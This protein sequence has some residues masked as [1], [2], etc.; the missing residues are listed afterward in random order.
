MS[1]FRKG[2]EMNRNKTEEAVLFSKVSKLLKDEVDAFKKEHDK[3]IALSVA[4]FT[5]KFLELIE[6]D[7]LNINAKIF[8]QWIFAEAINE[9]NFNLSKCKEILAK[10]L[11]FKN[12]RT[13][14]ATRLDLKINPFIEKEIITKANR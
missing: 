2:L 11:G 7:H 9:E 12:Y 4:V 14:K 8:C 1:D 10:K 3:N 6:E 13:L 5:H